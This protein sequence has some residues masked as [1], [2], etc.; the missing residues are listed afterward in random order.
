MDTNSGKDGMRDNSAKSDNC[1]DHHLTHK[2]H[3]RSI[4]NLERMFAKYRLGEKS[5]KNTTRL[6]I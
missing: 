6:G 2:R 1:S 4:Q 5:A 3:T